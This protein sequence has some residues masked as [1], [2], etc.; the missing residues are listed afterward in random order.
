METKLG[1]EGE[2]ELGFKFCF[3]IRNITAFIQW[4]LYLT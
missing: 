3:V 4:P 2:D 1:F